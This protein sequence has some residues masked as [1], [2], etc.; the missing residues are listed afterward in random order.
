[1][2]VDSQIHGS[3][4]VLV[5]HGALVS[6]ELEDFRRVVGPL[7]ASKPG[8]LVLDLHDVAYLD[9]GGIETLMTLC[10]DMRASA[11]RPKLANLTDTCREA[12]DLT[13]VLPRLEVFDTVEN[14]IRGCRR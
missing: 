7:I 8:R 13:S 4:T 14:A 2:R 10:A 5:P 12:L 3:I 9:S 11:T 6:S 1:M